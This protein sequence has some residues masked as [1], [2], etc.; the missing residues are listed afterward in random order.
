[1]GDTTT[2][3][4][5]PDV[6]QPAS[7]LHGRTRG[8]SR[9]AG[10]RGLTIPQ[11]ASAAALVIG[12]SLAG[13]TA[14]AIVLEDWVGVGDAS[15]IYLLA[16][17]LAAALFGTPAAVA[18]SVLS[19]LVYDF[20]FTEP[21]L[22]LA[23]ASPQ[24]WLSLLLFLVVAVVIGRLA[25]L[26][27]E[28]AEESRRR[29][30]EARSLFAISHSIATGPSISE[31]AGEIVSLLRAEAGLGRVWVVVGGAGEAR[32]LADSGAAGATGP[33]R[34]PF[35][36]PISW[37][38]RRRPGDLPAE[39]IQVHEPRRLQARPTESSGP[40]DA[41]R[42]LVQA[43]GHPYGTIWGS[44]DRSTGRP[45]R[46]ATRLL[47]LAADQ[48][49]LAMRRD[50]LRRA[51]T[52]AE[53]ARQ[54]NALKT[55]LLDSVSHDLRTPLSG[56]RAIAGSLMDQELELSDQRRREMAGAIDREAE[57]MGRFV[58]ELLDVSRVQA[59][60][61]V[62]D[63][64]IYPL[65]ELVE[66]VIDRLRPS[67]G[68]RDVT[69]HIPD[70]LSPVVVDGVMFDEALANLV[71]N[72]ALHAP[73][74]APVRLTARDR[75]DGAVDLVFEDGGPGVAAGDHERLFDRFYR[76]GSRSGAPPGLGIGLTIARGFVEAMHG[77]LEAGP[78]DLGG[79]AITMVLPTARVVDEAPAESSGSVRSEDEAHR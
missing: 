71:D 11:T 44:R 72:A 15:P 21:R 75:P 60:T 61:L 39:W 27:R 9:L 67:L 30:S 32:I 65:R 29:A 46:G 63:L 33:A 31:A 66:P 35:E 49:G 2:P 14:V 76:G 70:G 79:L 3:Q 6:P 64:E 19:V 13:A 25:A 74:P 4:A 68:E 24:E 77:R 62:P 53:I 73:P 69:I 54:S 17:V 18:T 51:A 16:V 34:P 12:V 48:L 28:R 56:I 22:T 37:V 58:R 40:L 57:R 36:A 52:D 26:L 42:V 55:A 59:G 1:M 43:D 50:Q 41:Y 10:L 38:L 45:D 23:V 20:L 7:G 5:T 47:A 8:D 78:S